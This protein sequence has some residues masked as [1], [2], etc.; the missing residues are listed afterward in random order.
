MVPKQPETRRV[1]YLDGLRGVAAFAVLFH[2]FVLGFEP[3]LVVTF[4]HGTFH[5]S[6]AVCIFFV[7]SGFVMSAAS[8]R[9][10]EFFALRCVKRYLRLAL[11]MLA[12]EMTAWLL[13]EIFP[14]ASRGSAAETGSLWAA[15][16]YSRGPLPLQSVP[17]DA[18]A[19]PFARGNAYLDSSLWTM[20]PELIGSLAIFVVYA[21]LPKR[22]RVAGA[23]AMAAMAAVVWK[24]YWAPCFAAGVAFWELRL[25]N[26]RA[27]AY[28]GLLVL[29]LGYLASII[30]E[31]FLARLPAHTN[32]WPL[33]AA[34]AILLVGGLLLC[35]PA[36]RL[37]ETSFPQFLGRIS[38][39]LYLV[40]QPLLLTVF[41]ALWLRWQPAGGEVGLLLAL[42]I[43]ASLAAG[44]AMTKAADV[45][46]LN[47]LKRLTIKGTKREVAPLASAA[48]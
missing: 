47:L 6:L 45:P 25:Q 34:A 2:H 16:H 36:K 17:I 31:P 46:T 28:V 29:S 15:A 43:A 10:S 4:L 20:R 13:V 33:Y 40:H 23:I 30:S 35:D 3:N 9:S 14:T 8:D 18:L 44:W 22:H 38:F 1:A 37:L 21:F 12:A 19:R 32:P 11:P 41:A 48:P 5:G 39:G 7:L 42:F 24:W 27:P 26:V